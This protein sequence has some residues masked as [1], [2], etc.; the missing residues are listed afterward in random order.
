ML[1]GMVLFY[2]DH[3][4]LPRKD[5]VQ[6]PV[7][8]HIKMLLYKGSELLLFWTENRGK[9]CSPFTFTG[10][11]NNLDRPVEEEGGDIFGCNEIA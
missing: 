2:G 10:R 4:G 1:E 11:I 7:T 3:Q 8:D 5:P 6:I 9:P